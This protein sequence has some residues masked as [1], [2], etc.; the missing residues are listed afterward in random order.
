[1]IATLLVALADASI[2]SG[3][4]MLVTGILSLLLLA[5]QCVSAPQVPGNQR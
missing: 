4:D 5:N 1:M 2:E 3:A